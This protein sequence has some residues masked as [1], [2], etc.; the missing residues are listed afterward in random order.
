MTEKIKKQVLAVRNTGRTNMFD[1]PM[2]Q[3]IANELNLFDLVVWLEDHKS[4]YVHFIMFGEVENLE[5]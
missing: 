5:K 1:I 4:D 2:V 3:V